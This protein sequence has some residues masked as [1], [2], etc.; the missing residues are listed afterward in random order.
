MPPPPSQA[1]GRR[2]PAIALA[3]LVA[4]A[5][6]AFAIDAFDAGPEVRKP[7]PSPV[8]GT[9]A[10]SAFDGTSREWRLFTIDT[11]GTSDARISI[12]LPGEAIHPDWSPDGARLAFASNRDGADEI[13]L[14]PAAGGAPRRLTS[15]R[16]DDAV[17]CLWSR[18]DGIIYAWARGRAGRGYWAIR[19]RDGHVSLLLEGGL[20]TRQLGVAI[21]TDGHRLLFPV[22]ERL[23]DLWVADLVGAAR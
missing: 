9:I 16:W 23:S 20:A 13:Y 4:V 18:A 2:I 10:Y 22:W 21:A 7:G 5:G 12:E 3:I 19:P 6:I 14:L 15:E 8:V 1:T 17:P 11:D